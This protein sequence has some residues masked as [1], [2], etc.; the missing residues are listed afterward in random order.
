MVTTEQVPDDLISMLAEGR[1]IPFV[2]AGFSRNLG[3]P[4][5]HELLGTVYKELRAEPPPE[6]AWPPDEDYDTL[7]RWGQTDPLQI[8]EY[9]FHRAGGEFGPILYRLSRQ[10][11]RPEDRPLVSSTPHIELA[12]LDPRLIY[13]T[14]YDGL[15]EDTY[16]TLGC[17]VNS[18]VL[19]RDLAALG[20]DDVTQVVKYHGD[21]RYESTI[22]F[23]QRQYYARLGLDSPLDIKLRA[24]LFGRSVL[25][26][27][28]GFQDIN[29]RLIWFKLT[30]AMR[31]V[32][33]HRRPLSYIVLPARDPVLEQLYKADGI[34]PIVLSDTPDP[35][36]GQV[37]TAF[38]QLML[39]FSLQAANR[40]WRDPS[41]P[42]FVS[43]GLLDS[44]ADAFSADSQTAEEIMKGRVARLLNELASRLLPPHDA[45]K[46]QVLSARLSDV[47]RELWHGAQRARAE[48]V[49]TP[50]LA[51]VAEKH[52]TRPA[53]PGFTFFYLGALLKRDSRQS[54]PF[55]FKGDWG[56]V[57]NGR[58]PI[59]EASQIVAMLEQ[60]LDHGEWSED[61]LYGAYVARVIAN[62][63][64]TLEA[65]TKAEAE[66][67]RQRAAAAADCAADLHMDAR[68]IVVRD[69][70][71][72]LSWSSE[73]RSTTAPRVSDGQPTTTAGAEP[74]AGRKR[75]RPATKDRSSRK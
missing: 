71:P 30:Q 19:P 62:P 27:G 57:V 67:A 4:G 21:L 1:V 69:D 26:L 50:M 43:L 49:I 29:V 37:S 39:E 25:F 12:N 61:V 10:L 54:L 18:V 53:L 72:V 73:Q 31:G 74:T 20:G 64:M 44:L 2:G 59:L 60:Q 63:K 55:L 45:D 28:Y 13:T 47:V 36:T 11:V 16:R 35:N 51:Q 8:A 38:G 17:R 24:D 42:R 48:G 14:N 34:H 22:V 56:A 41:R 40:G 68:S 58:L 33:R 52:M 15:I 3:L 75:A 23:T 5:W 9:L 7:S 65:K 66:A 70:F 46:P 6:P 32:S